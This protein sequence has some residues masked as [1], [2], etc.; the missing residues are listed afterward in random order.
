VYFWR[1]N[2]DT[3]GLGIQRELEKKNNLGKERR[4]GR[5]KLLILK[6]FGLGEKK[7]LP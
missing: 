2:I 5:S 7:K 1:E 6:Q 3:G 4:G